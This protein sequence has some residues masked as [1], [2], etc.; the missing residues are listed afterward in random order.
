MIYKK[1]TTILI[2][3][4]FCFST[5]ITISQKLSMPQNIQQA[6]KKETRNFD[7]KPGTKY[8]QNSGK[9]NINVSLNP[10]TNIITGEEKIKYFNNSP[11]DLNKIA[12]RFVNNILKK[13][14]KLQN[15]QDLGL[16]IYF[17]SIDGKE[18]KVDSK[19]WGTVELIDLDKSIKAST[20]SEI[21]IKWSYQLSVKPGRGGVID[22][23]TFFASYFYP[24]VSV[25]DDYNGWDLLPHNGRLEFY[26]DFNDYEFSV[27]VPANYVV[28]AT[29]DLIN[30]ED[31]LQPEILSRLNKSMLSD[32][33][34]KIATFSEMMDNKVT[35][36]KKFNTWRFVA[37][38]ISDITFGA[39]KNYVWDAT[40]LIVGGEKR[41]SLQSAYNDTAKDFRNF[42]KWSQESLD[43]FSN[44]WPGVEYPYSK[45]TSFQGFADME[46]PMMINDETTNDLKFSQ[47]VQNHEIA[48]TYFPFYM[49]I[50]ETRYAFMDE[51]WATTFEYFICIEQNGKNYADSVYKAFRS[52]FV[53]FPVE[54]QKQPIMTP[55][56]DTDPRAFGANAYGKASLSYIGLRDLL[57]D[58]LFKKA[59]HYYMETWHGKHPIPWDYFN[60]INKGSGKKLDKYFYNWFYDTV[61]IDLKIK[62]KKNKNNS[63]SVNAINE[64]G[65]FIPFDVVVN[66]EDGSFEKVHFSPEAWF[67]SKIKKIKI[68]TSRKAKSIKL[69]GGI[70]ADN[71]PDDNIVYLN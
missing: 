13:N 27:T 51:G 16:K 2:V 4:V 66:F 41:I 10:Q 36:Q 12:I 69:D 1:I 17:L 33:V 26:N 63:I 59:L 54:I 48:H 6:Y 47:L 38:N 53:K 7:G 32:T 37:N 11:D 14:G 19:S 31:V 15:E 58:T 20:S 3:V 42:S 8:W 55:Y 57:G 65:L 52:R 25:Y 34:I 28:W 56:E 35:V 44:V 39:S 9:Y 24:R 46:Y 18:Y 71:T 43:Y 62:L 21:F 50:N 23:T 5:K 61:Y 67:N 68:K 49:G 70:F 29:G 60:C 30:A 64:G 40:A 22:S 45:M